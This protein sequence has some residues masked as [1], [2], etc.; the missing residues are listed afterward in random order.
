MIVLKSI[1]I[2]LETPFECK[3]CEKQFAQSGN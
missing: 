2:K 1:K 3:E